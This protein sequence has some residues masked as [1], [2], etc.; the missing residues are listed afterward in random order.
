VNGGKM[1]KEKTLS[2][3]VKWS[4]ILGGINWGLVLINPMWNIAS[5]IASNLPGFYIDSIIYGVIGVSG[6]ILLIEQFKK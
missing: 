1:P 3:I 5:I 6:V 4:L 2:K